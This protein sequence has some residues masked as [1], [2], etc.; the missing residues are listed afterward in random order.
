MRRRA[1]SRAWPGS[2]R[3][4]RRSRPRADRSRAARRRR[5]RR[6]ARRRARR[7]PRAMRE[8]TSRTYNVLT[9]H[10]GRRAAAAELKRELDLGAQQL[11]DVAYALLAG[12][13]ETPER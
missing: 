2:A 10:L 8:R 13:H 6:T 9:G 4:V 5:R 11:E 3:R 1:P 7:L 12:D